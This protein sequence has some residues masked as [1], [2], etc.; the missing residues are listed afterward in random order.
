MIS[1]D[2]NAK[3]NKKK[4]S[5][6]SE[7]ID[8][9][10]QYNTE[11]PPKKKRKMCISNTENEETDLKEDGSNEVPKQKFDFR[12]KILELVQTK[13]TISLKKLEKKI[14]KLY[15]KEFRG[16]ECPEKILKKYNKKLKKIEEVEIEG[17][18]IKLVT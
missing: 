14:V 17:D 13:G 11:V 16:D 8:Q 10:E 6:E 3:S 4:K 9:T 2:G 5:K 7:L 12:T 15:L 18:T 1:E